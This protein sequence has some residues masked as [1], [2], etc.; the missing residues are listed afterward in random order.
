MKPRRSRRAFALGAL[1]TLAALAAC[2]TTYRTPLDPALFQSTTLAAAPA[3][4]ADAQRVALSLEDPGQV[5]RSPTLSH[6]SARFEVPVGHIA[7]AAALLALRREFTT[8]NSVAAGSAGGALRLQLAPVTMELKSER[9]YFIPLPYLWPQRVDVTLRLR[10][11]VR[12]LG[13]GGVVR[14][15]QDYDSGA[16]LWVPRRKSFL[17][18]E[19]VQ[20]G[21]QRL[22]HELSLRLMRQAARDARAWAEH[23][24]LRER[25]L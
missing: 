22:T 1:A 15:A 2:T 8:V 12:V 5:F 10:L 21:V 9:I 3:M 19:P 17:V 13:P 18:L 24:R 25:V 20:E 6:F 11:T 4:A 23:D 14:W 16:E 7:E